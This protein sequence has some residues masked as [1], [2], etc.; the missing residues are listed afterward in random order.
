[1]LCF[2]YVIINSITYYIDYYPQWYCRT[3]RGWLEFIQIV[4]FVRYDASFVSSEVIAYIYSL[5][6][7]CCW[8]CLYFCCLQ[9][10]K[11]FTFLLYGLCHPVCLHRRS[12]IKKGEDVTIRMSPQNQYYSKWLNFATGWRHVWF[13]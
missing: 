9:I 5:Y 10:F 11:I 1:M 3:H 2:C 13:K 8:C 7:C 6:Q 4:Y 12:E